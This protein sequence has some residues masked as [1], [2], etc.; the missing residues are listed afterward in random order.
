M[1]QNSRLVEL[2]IKGLEAE[3]A[4]I[5]Q[6]LMELRNQRTP[7]TATN[8]TPVAARQEPQLQAPEPLSHGER[9]LSAYQDAKRALNQIH[10]ELMDVNPR[11]AR[12]LRDPDLARQFAANE[13]NRMTWNSTPWRRRGGC[14][15]Q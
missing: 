3:K 4:R 10:R 5:E 11:A 12:S 2:A 8:S 6:E 9:Y 7:R 13:E 14:A 15:H 1:I